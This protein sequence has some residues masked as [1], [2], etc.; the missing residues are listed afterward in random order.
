MTKEH[1]NSKEISF[2]EEKGRYRGVLAWLMSTDHKRIGIQYL[3]ALMSFFAVGVSLGILIRLSLISPGWLF[4]PQ[5]YDEIF[6]THGIIMI[7]LFIIPG[8][9]VA[10]G[11]FFL[12]IMIVQGM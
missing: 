1:V 10:F 8:I 12:P 3:G 6:S 5:T 11:N 2:Y 9:P 7:F 4:G